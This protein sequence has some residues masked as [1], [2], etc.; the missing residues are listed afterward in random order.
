MKN[1]DS[2]HLLQ[3]CDSGAKM[4]VSSINGV[5]DK[6]NNETLKSILTES[7]NHHEALGNEV[8][9]A[10]NST[11]SETK[12]PGMVAKGMSWMKTNMKMTMSPDD[13]DASAADLITD[14]C[15]MGIKSLNEYLNKY[16]NADDESK[17]LCQNLISIEEKLCKDLRAYL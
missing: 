14:G 11:H 8:H 13:S 5:L 16:K 17:H 9:A 10:L 6:V 7:R 15:N 1:E 12:E 4:A 3:E 2:I